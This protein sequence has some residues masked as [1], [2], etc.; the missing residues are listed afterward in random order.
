MDN[1]LID[2]VKEFLK[3]AFS[4]SLLLFIIEEMGFYCH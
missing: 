4:A 1:I 3:E 2:G